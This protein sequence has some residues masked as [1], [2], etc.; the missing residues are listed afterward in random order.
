MPNAFQYAWIGHILVMCLIYATKISP[1]F[2][3]P[4]MPR[5]IKL[6]G[7]CCLLSAVLC[8]VI[9][10]TTAVLHIHRLQTLT[11]CV[12]AQSQRTCTCFAGRLEDP[13]DDEEG[14]WSASSGCE[15][16]F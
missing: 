15:E 1:L 14:E 4:F 3:T 2:M 11:E 16:R 5:Q 6:S 13:Y 8:V 12:F 7:F 10:V 9:T